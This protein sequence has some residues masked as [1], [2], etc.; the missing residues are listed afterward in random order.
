[1]SMNFSNYLQKLLQAQATNPFAFGLTASKTA[2]NEDIISKL[3]LFS[4]ASAEEL[5]NIDLEKL[6]EAET[7]SEA[8]DSNATTDEK[9]LAE[10]VKALMDMEEIQT[11]ADLDK[12]GKVSEEEAQEFL[13]KI[14]GNDGDISS[15]TMEDIDAAIEELGINLQDVAEKTIDEVLKETEVEEAQEVKNAPSSNSVSGG[16]SAGRSSGAHSPSSAASKP[17]TPADTAEEIRTQIADKNKEIADVEADAEAQIAEEEKAKE[18]AMKQ[19]GVAEEEYKAY[20]EKEQE[21]ENKIQDKET[22]ISDKD[23]EIRDKESTISSNGNYI[24]SLE[25]QIN[26]NNSKKVS[27]N[28]EGASDKNAQIDSQNSQ[29]QGKIDSIKQENERLEQEK[30]KAEQDKADLEKQKTDLET[31]KQNLLNDTLN[32]S[33]GFAKGI[34]SATAV[35]EIKNSIQQHDTKISEIRA[36]KN[37]KV[38]GIKNE[39][40]TLEVKLKD[41]EAQE[42]RNNFIKDNSFKSGLGLTGEELVDVAKQ[43]LAQYGESHGYCATGVSRTFAMAYGL[44]LHGN[45]CDWDTNMDN[46]VEQG[47]FEEVTGDYA[48]SADLANL[49]AGAVVCWEATGGSD[50]GAKYGHVTIADGQGGEISDHYAS[51]IYKTIGGRSDQYKVYIPVC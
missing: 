35:Q 18:D 22:A 23:N 5:A 17:Q 36:D 50:G 13:T 44:D 10:M 41:V 31:Q 30:V 7:A 38:A 37:T 25:S 46:L 26:S 20:Q 40:Q 1:M 39:I 28:E 33:E 51:S 49:P 14:M 24:S 29:L 47:A 12:N 16:N 2:N 8:L 11:A 3:S 45:G 6:L 15:L 27:S 9:A 42:E 43:M 32:N 19:A 21:L 4:E 48:T 34:G